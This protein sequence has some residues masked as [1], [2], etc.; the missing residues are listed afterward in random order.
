[1]E[2]LQTALSGLTGVLVPKKTKTPWESRWL[3]FPFNAEMV[4]RETRQI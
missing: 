1:M 2:P 3:N 4:E